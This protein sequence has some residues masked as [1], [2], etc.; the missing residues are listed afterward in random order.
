MTTLSG[1]CVCGVNCKCTKC[2]CKSKRK[3]NDKKKEKNSSNNNDNTNNINIISKMEL[4]MMG[5]IMKFL[6]IATDYHK[7]NVFPDTA[8]AYR[9]E[10]KTTTET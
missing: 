7:W 1:K 9:K 3:M 5:M 4:K 6:L 8:Y 10:T 2:M